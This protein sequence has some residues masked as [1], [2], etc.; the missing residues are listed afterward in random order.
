[1]LSTGNVNPPFAVSKDESSVFSLGGEE[2]QGLILQSTS[3]GELV[4]CFTHKH[5]GA[6]TSLT[7]SV[8]PDRLWSASSDG[9]VSCYELKRGKKTIQRLQEQTAQVE[10]EQ[11]GVIEDVTNVESLRLELSESDEEQEV[12]FTEDKSIEEAAH[13]N[14]PPPIEPHPLES[15]P[16]PMEPHPIEGA[17]FEEELARDP[18]LSVSQRRASTFLAAPKTRVS[19]VEIDDL[20]DGT[21]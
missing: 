1:M 3:S 14:G 16:P 13:G 20:D 12:A 19:M 18:V 17:I 8:S 5:E 10:E 4:N 6:I 9:V 11:L 15:P 21:V 7:F 2:S